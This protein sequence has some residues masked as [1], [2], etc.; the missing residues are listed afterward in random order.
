MP[1]KFVRQARDSFSAEPISQNPSESGEERAAH[2]SQPPEHHNMNSELLSKECGESALSDS[3]LQDLLSIGTTQNE[4]QLHR[5]SSKNSE[6]FEKWERE[7]MEELLSQLNGHLGNVSLILIAWT[8]QVYS[9]TSQSSIRITFW[10][11]KIL[12]I[13]S[14]LMLIS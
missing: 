4:E 11:E 5:R 6:P 12:L 13:I 7:E 14:C 10:R 1:I 3:S 2:E 8:L 9:E